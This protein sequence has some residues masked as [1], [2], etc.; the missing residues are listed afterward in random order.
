[1][2]P[3]PQVLLGGPRRVYP[4]WQVKVTAFPVL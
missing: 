3:A 4:G 2:E 1:M